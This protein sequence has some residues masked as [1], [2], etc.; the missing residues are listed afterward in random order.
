MKQLWIAVAAAAA[1]AARVCAQVELVDT[2]AAE[3]L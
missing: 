1:P 3:A 2:P